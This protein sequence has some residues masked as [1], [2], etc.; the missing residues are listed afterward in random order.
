MRFLTKNIQ[1]TQAGVVV[2][3]I[4]E[5]DDTRSELFCHLN[6]LSNGELEKQIYTNK[7][8][9]GAQ[10]E[11]FK[12]SINE[13]FKV[14]VA[15]LGK[16]NTLTR[17]KFSQN[18]AQ[19]AKIAKSMTTNQSVAFE[20]IEKKDECTCACGFGKKDAAQ[21]TLTAARIGFYEF[22]KYLKDKK[23]QIE[24]IE[25]L[26]NEISQDIEKGAQIGAYTSF[27]M[28]FA[29]DL[30]N[31]QAQVVTPKYVADLA[32]QIAKEHK[33]EAKI[34]YTNEIKDL[35]MNAFLAV[36]QGSIHEPRFVHLTFKPKTTPRKKI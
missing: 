12:Y 22:S 34:Y 1:E 9:K 16:K 31:E 35:G 7:I 11:N 17:Q 14:L 6:K 21:I 13:D 36:G 26:D 27:A 24:T 28:K 5:D 33:L 23:P 3:F 19:I 18:I 25:L 8:V 4:F 32:E 2:C 30:V 10:G 15:G 20:L 29:K